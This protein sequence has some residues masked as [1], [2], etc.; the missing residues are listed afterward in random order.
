MPSIR[1]QRQWVSIHELLDLL[2][3]PTVLP[4]PVVVGETPEDAVLVGGT[5][6][7]T[8]ET[9]EVTVDTGGAMALEVAPGVGVVDAV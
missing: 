8:V 7:I 2:V 6:T 3:D 4:D 9:P 5:M 1:I